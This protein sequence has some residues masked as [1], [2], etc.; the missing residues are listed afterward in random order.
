MPE[1]R[2]GEDET[3]TKNENQSATYNIEN[4]RREEEAS[5]S[6]NVKTEPN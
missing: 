4:I 1:V 2:I 6:E 5:N 3:S